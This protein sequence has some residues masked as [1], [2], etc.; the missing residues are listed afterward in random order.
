MQINN[1]KAYIEKFNQNDEELYPQLITNQ[2]SLDWI[3][4]E[5]PRFECPDKILE[6]TYYFRWW[7]FGKHLKQ[8][9]EGRIITEFLPDVLGQVHII[10]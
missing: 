2:K 1:Y 8:T 6:E 3:E 7:T 9:K 4:R 5:I 10:R